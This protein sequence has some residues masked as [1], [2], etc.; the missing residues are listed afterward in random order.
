MDNFSEKI[1]TLVQQMTLE[2]KAGLCSGLDMWHTKPVEREL[3][4]SPEMKKLAGIPSM[5]MTDGPHGLRKQKAG[6]SPLNVGDSVQAVCFPTASALAASFDRELLHRL[7]ETLGTECQAEDVAILLGPGV[8]IK[9]SPL[10]GRNFEYLSEDPYLAGKLAAAYINGLQSR[11][12]GASLKHFAANNQETHRMTSNSVVD[13]RALHEIYLASFEGA[14]K[15]GKPKSVMGSYNKINGTYSAENGELLTGILREKWGFEG[16][17]VTDWGAVRDRVKGIQ[18]G[19]DLEMPGSGGANDKKIIAAVQSGVLDEALLDRTAARVLRVVFEYLEKRDETAVFDRDADHETAVNIA[20]ECAVLLKNEGSLLPLKKEAKIAVIGEFAQKPRFQGGGS[21]FINATRITGAMD[22]LQGKANV[23][24]CRGYDSR[25]GVVD[26]ALIDEAV[27]AAGNADVAVIFAGLP[28]AYESEG[29]DRKHIDLPENQNALIS[30]V[31]K[32]Q[33][34]TVVALHN[35]APVAMPWIHG[36]KAVLE[37]YLGGEGV[38]E[39]AVSLLYGDANPSGK[40]AETF[41]LKI[42]DNPSYLNFPGHRDETVYHE[43]V[44]V[45][46]RYYDKKEMPVLFPFGHGLSYTSFVY[47]DINIGKTKMKGAETCTVT[48]KIKNTGSRAGKEAV[49]LYVRNH[50]NGIDRPVRELKGF[51]KVSLDPGEEKTVS[52]TLDK[53][54]FA[55]YEPAVHD[56]MVE[57]G[58]FAIELG[59]SSRDIRLEASIAVESDKEIPIVFTRYSPIGDIMAAAKGQAVLGPM[60]EK[61]SE[62]MGGAGSV[63]LGEGSAEMLAAIMKEMPLAAL[64]GFG[65]MS[66]EQLNGLLAALNG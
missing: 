19:L 54:A 26:T 23:T 66:D 58:E 27:K 22:V 39:A 14:V 33:K 43:G 41:P 50:G 64:A 15:G 12:V 53:R 29:F 16:F 11:G 40:L 46:Y 30:A 34:N 21:S 49:Q 36:A 24:F 32:A 6:D 57:S 65:N 42:S 2:E 37:M 3:T 55:Y 31:C 8:N 60:M 47:S 61:M 28:D 7:G 13:E 25:S 63:N 10:C 38:G 44:Y 59:A 35:G 62:Q 5:M 56:W 45:G 48:A 52:F 1:K 4:F 17:V 20:S 51:T 9:R 18:A